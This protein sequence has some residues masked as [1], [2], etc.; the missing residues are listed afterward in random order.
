MVTL[1][2]SRASR[3]SR[4]CTYSWPQLTE[5]CPPTMSVISVSYLSTST[6]SRIIDNSFESIAVFMYMISEGPEDLDFVACPSIRLGVS[7]LAQN[8]FRS[9]DVDK[10]KT[11][12]GDIPRSSLM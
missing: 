10:R 6:F 11:I 3:N 2:E 1:T 12:V 8:S 7:E 9:R 5:Q 4:C